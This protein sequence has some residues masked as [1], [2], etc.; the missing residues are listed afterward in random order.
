M[1]PRPSRISAETR[2][3]WRNW[4]PGSPTGAWIRPFIANATGRR[5]TSLGSRRAAKTGLGFSELSSSRV[6]PASGKPPPLISRLL[7]LVTRLWNSMP[8]TREA[9]SSL[10]M[11]PTLITRPLTVTSLEKA[12]W[13]VSCEVLP[14]TTQ[15]TTV[16]GIDDLSSRT[17][18]I[19]D[20]V[21]GMSA[22]DRGG[23]GALNALIKKTKV[24]YESHA[25]ADLRFPSSSSAT[26][27]TCRR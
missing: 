12:S 3:R 15:S 24:G 5:A 23:V 16:T 2:G 1:R 7:S 25:A 4:G 6:R 17:C 22:G 14:L 27:A 8:A 10:R 9:R 26:T 18:L 20:E 19:M 21:D 11:R 13:S